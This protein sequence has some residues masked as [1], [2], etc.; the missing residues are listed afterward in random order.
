MP[1]SEKIIPMKNR[2]KIKTRL[3]SMVAYKNAGLLDISGPLEV[4]TL[5][6]VFISKETGSDI[7]AYKTEILSTKKGPVVMSSGIT[8]YADRAFSS[9]AAG[10][11]TLM[12]AGGPGADEA[13]KDEELI[14]LLR[15]VKNRI[16][17]LAS[18]CNGA[19]IFAEADLLNRRKA[20][21]HWAI[22]D[23]L[24]RDYPEVQVEHDTIF[25]RDGHI[26]SSAGVTAGIDLS[27]AL[28]E[29]DY[30][31]KIAMTVAKF[32]VLFMKRQG[33]QSQF[34]SYLSLQSNGNGHLKGLPEWIINNPGKNLS[35]EELAAKAAMSER[36]FSRVFTKETGMSPGKFIE[37]V[38][39]E[40]AA[41]CLE[42]TKMSFDQIAEASGFRSAERMRRAFV[43]HLHVLPGTYRK[44][45][46]I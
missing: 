40:Y 35:I 39:I 23:Q 16:R 34:S 25:V 2:K 4:F 14:K 31:R 33:G 36:N 21:T 44:R 17:R 32:L 26:Y 43:R 28:L 29:E 22:C 42:N 37:S 15:K 8:L 45:F 38:R 24:A 6:N 11:D 27:L 19:I 9:S 10:T 1:L 18:I 5:A 46:G 30:G 7:P 41:S 12:V 13:A 3:I 20:T